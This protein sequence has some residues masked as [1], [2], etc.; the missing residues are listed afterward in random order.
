M[1][2]FEKFNTKEYKT[3]EELFK[4]FG[5]EMVYQVKG[6]YVNT[7]SE[8]YPETPLVMINDWY[9]N[10]PQHQL[11]QIKRMLDNDECMAAIKEGK[12]GFTIQK[13]FQEEYQKECYSAHWVNYSEPDDAGE[14]GGVNP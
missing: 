3:L 6:V 4:E 7:N 1:F 5:E 12:L 2:N 9:V 11:I 10:I 14:L 13:Y 8:Y